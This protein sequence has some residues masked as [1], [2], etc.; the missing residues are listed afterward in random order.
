M[1][2]SSK[3]RAVFPI[4]VSPF[5][6]D[7]LTY[8]TIYNLHFCIVSIHRLQRLAARS[9]SKQVQKQTISS[10]GSVLKKGDIS[11]TFGDIRGHSGTFRLS[12]T[13]GDIPIFGKVSVPFRGHL[14]AF[15][16]TFG[17]TFRGHL[18]G[19]SGAFGDIRVHFGLHISF[20]Q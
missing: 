8:Q 2:P 18:G 17:L 6:S 20:T 1:F 19:Y 7:S 4:V 13:S 11:G 16:G 9:K 14:G 3:L 10:E 15:E 12:G 5:K